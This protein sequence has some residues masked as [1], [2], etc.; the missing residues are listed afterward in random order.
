MFECDAKLSADG[1]VYLLHDTALDR[2]TNAQGPAHLR[3]WKELS[4]IDAGSWYSESFKG[5]PIPTLE[6]IISFCLDSKCQLNIEIKASPGF[7]A[8]TG[9]MVAREVRRLWTGPPPLLTSFEREALQSALTTA[10][11]IPRG[12]LMQTLASDWREAARNLK[13]TALVCHEKF[14][15]ATLIKEI[16]ERGM[17][18]LAYNVNDQARA[19]ALLGMGL[20]AI[21]TDQMTFG[22][23][24]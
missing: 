15:T 21:I 16:H 18:A 6:K 24:Q 20:D 9:E 12:L 1:V 17:S 10:P 7:A 23:T 13:C 4:L 14:L 22:T 3:T 19:Q 8:S 11:E 5:E 2:T